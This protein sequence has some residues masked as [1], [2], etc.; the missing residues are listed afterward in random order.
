MEV[1]EVLDLWPE[2]HER[3]R[4]WLSP[5]EAA[6]RGDEPGLAVLIRAVSG[7]RLGQGLPEPQWGQAI[8]GQRGGP[9][10]YTPDSARQRDWESLGGGGTFKKKKTT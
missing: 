1:A 7:G 9:L 5:A 3:A 2:A 8:L 6:I 10:F 4:H